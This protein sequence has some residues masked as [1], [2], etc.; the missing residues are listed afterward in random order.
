[1][2]SNQTGVIKWRDKITAL[3][4]E[5]WENAST[6]DLTNYSYTIASQFNL[7][8]IAENVSNIIKGASDE[9]SAIMIQTRLLRLLCESFVEALLTAS[10]DGK[11]ITKS[12]V[13]RAKDLF[14]SNK[15]C[16]YEE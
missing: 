1:M 2:G 9:Q 3:F 4:F 7:D 6:V 12:C 11:Y 5:A 13:K 16:R 15:S 14:L 8:R 10:D